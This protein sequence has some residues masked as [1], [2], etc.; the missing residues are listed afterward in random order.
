MKTLITGVAGFIGSNL[1]KFLLENGFIVYGI[2][3]YSVGN[4]KSIK[5]LSDHKNFN[6]IKLDLSK[7]GIIKNLPKVEAIVHLA[8]KKIPRY[9]NSLETLMVNTKMTENILKVALFYKAKLIYASTSDV[10]GLNKS[11]PFK[12]DSDLVLGPPTVSRW[13]YAASKIYDEHICLAFFDKYKVPCVILRFFGVYGPGVNLSWRGG[14]FGPFISSCLEE[15]KIEIHGTGEQI[16][17]FTY[18][19]D[20][21][22]GIYMCIISRKSTGQIFNISSD[23]KISITDLVKKIEKISGNKA[24]VE[25]VKYSSFY[26]GNYQDVMAK[27]P[28]TEKASKIIKFKAETSL[29]VGIKKTIDWYLKN[30]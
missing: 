11:L 19:D 2:D 21:V 16:R 5:S 24:K 26:G 8:A 17:C 7:T 30:K 20:V 1:A 9:E 18:I 3:N 15:K 29:D 23:E 25:H 13:S 22:K 28:S 12:E 6:F 4:S 14:P 27:I 10:Y